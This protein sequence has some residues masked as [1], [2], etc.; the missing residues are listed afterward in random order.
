V[1]RYALGAL[2]RGRTHP[3]DI[4]GEVQDGDV[5]L[6]Y[7]GRV[8]QFAAVTAAA[9]EVEARYVGVPGD[10]GVLVAAA[11][12]TWTLTE[13]E[14][15]VMVFVA[16]GGNPP[17][18]LLAY[19]ED[20][21]G[22]RTT[23]EYT[24]GRV[25][26]VA[27]ADGLATTYQYN[28]AGR[29]VSATDPFG[30]ASTFSYD[31]ANEHLV[32]ST[33]NGLASTYSYITGQGPALE[34]AL[35]SVSLPDGRVMKF[36]YDSLGRVVRSSEADSGWEQRVV[37][38]PG[39][40]RVVTGPEG[41][42][43]DLRYNRFGQL[44]QA[45]G[46]LGDRSEFTYDAAHNLTGLAAPGG[47][48]CAMAYDA[49][50][51]RTALVHGS[52][53]Q[54]SATYGAFGLLE[55]LA[56]PLGRVTAYQRDG[57]GN[58]LSTTY[59]DGSQ[60][61]QTVDAHGELATTTNR[62][63]QTTRYQRD[64]QR[65][66][67][68]VENPDATALDYTYDGQYRLATATSPAGTLALGY[69]A[70]NRVTDVTYPGGRSL[71]YTYDGLGRRT[72]MTDQDGFQVEYAYDAVGRLAAVSTGARQTLVSYAYDRGGRLAREDR[73]NGTYSTY[74]YDAA[75]RLI[76]LVHRA[77]DGSELA[78]FA[79]GYDAAGR[80][81]SVATG[82][83]TWY[84]AYDGR[85]QLIQ[86]V[87][88]NGRTLQYTYD[89]AGNRT[90]V[91][92][93]GA[94]TPYAV[95]PLDQYVS[96]GGMARQYDADG[97]LTGSAEGSGST[98]AYDAQGRLTAASAGPS[99]WSWEYDALG[100]RAAMTASGRRTEYLVDPTGI[101]TLVAEYDAGGNLAAH[102][103]HGFGP[104]CRIDASGEIAFYGFDG[105]ANAALLTGPEG[106]V[107][108]RYAYL[109]FGEPLRCDETVPNPFRFAGR[110]GVLTDPSGLVQMRQR[111]Y[112]PAAG[113]FL[114]PDPLGPFGGNANL[115]TYAANAPTLFTDPLGLYQSM[116]DM[117][118]GEY[119][120]GFLDIALDSDYGHFAPNPDYD[121][122]NTGITNYLQNH[123][124]MQN[125]Q[126][127]FGP[128][129]MVTSG[130]FT[131]QELQ[132][133]AV[134]AGLMAHILTGVNVN[135][136]IDQFQTSFQGAQAL[137][138]YT[139]ANV[140][141]STVNCGIVT[142]P[143]NSAAATAYQQNQDVFNQFVLH[144]CHNPIPD[145]PL[146]PC[147]VLP[148]ADP[149]HNG[150]SPLD[151]PSCPKA[152]SSPPYP[153]IMP[154]SDYCVLQPVITSQIPIHTAI[155]PNEIEGPVGTGGAGWI[156]AQPLGYTIRFENQ[157]AATASAQRVVVT[158]ALDADTDW[159]RFELGS[160]GFGNVH[161]P[162]PSGLQSYTGR[163]DL[164]ATLGLDVDFA[165]ALD[166]QSGVVTWTFT[167][168]DPAT[169]QPTRDPFAGFLPPNVAP[170]EGEGYVRYSVRPLAGATS[171]SVIQAQASIVFD[172]NDAI[173]TNAHVN[174]LDVGVPVGAVTALPAY[175]P[176]PDFTVRWTGTDDPGGSGVASYDVF[177]AEDGG[178]FTA[179]LSRSTATS[180]VF[181]G[182]RGHSYAFYAVARD[183]VGHAE[184]QLEPLAE[185]QTRVLLIHDDV[186]RDGLPDWFEAGIINA[187]P[188]DA[189]VDFTDVRPGDD[190]ATA[191]PDGEFMAVL[192]TAGV[193]AGGGLWDLTGQYEATTKGNRLTL[194]LLHDSK[195]KLSGTATYTVAEGLVVTMPIRGSVKGS[196]G[197]ITMAGA[198][199]GSDPS[200]AVSVSLKLDLTLDASNRKLTGP[201]TGST[202]TSTGST[203]VNDTVSFDIP[204]HMDGTWMLQFHL[205][206]TGRAVA[207]TATLTLS[208]DVS[209]S[210]AVRGRSV[211]QAAVLNLAGAP[212][213]P[214]ATA[215]GIRT[216]VTPMVGGW[217]RLD[218]LLGSGY[219][220]VLRH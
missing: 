80:R 34:H 186:D 217:A 207:G 181:P 119:G 24:A 114:E 198:L 94:A 39:P 145:K 215:M 130:T 28:A 219:G 195:G 133:P 95:N 31:A 158:L 132:S 205:E 188:G 140:S 151:C 8:R 155:D 99:A 193:T 69:D 60:A 6:H 38:G 61:R 208:N 172:T 156:A 160:A 104:V 30:S 162:L 131:Q 153:G 143:A 194:G 149:S 123:P 63:G 21:N 102:Y 3:Y 189:I 45:V 200:H 206:R 183:G 214:A 179:W 126:H 116:E 121:K 7:P 165:A 71:H 43:V 47:S 184:V 74:A 137:A 29:L 59:P 148:V 175:S 180:A 168:I 65:R 12:G 203:T 37:Y 46:P 97:D 150:R 81:A 18:H 2:G 68:Q 26:R 76:L 164:R 191:A 77:A 197:S 171:G 19:G 204:G 101:G 55:R 36:E 211:G 176:Y 120:M 87:L 138:P 56:D 91:S 42:V 9:G 199:R 1:P 185:T 13:P 110:Q 44:G 173:L 220:Q 105:N 108:N 129:G 109:P 51:Q 142:P 210:F 88:P 67:S 159:S 86:A 103:V 117:V 93:D 58:L 115:Y 54:L 124:Y 161:I 196:S 49:A 144:N 107:L 5:L 192:N 113:R 89:L 17:R 57:H 100:N 15:G 64:G 52:G 152:E 122:I 106:T 98:Y 50:G 83:G 35:A 79:Y 212:D 22:N 11:S 202:R 209:H 147:I 182:E 128:D 166:A 127:L 40:R 125:A 82:E 178:P 213:D 157:P 135:Y 41:G 33:A 154:T 85:S 112:E 146:A 62:R 10:R 218:A 163:V 66:L 187:D 90:T 190:F 170:P 136:A 48:R 201:L 72:G 111:W 23:L 84:Y 20:R 32:N 139:Y 70:A 92:D 4:W 73:A 53:G 96:I 167:S 141:G 177:V 75:G 169:G 174:T 16:D 134:Q 118:M 216:T 27:F 14:G 25:T 78:R